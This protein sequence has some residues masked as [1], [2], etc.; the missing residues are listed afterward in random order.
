MTLAN[1]AARFLLEL[2]G[3]GAVGYWGYQAVDGMPARI[4]LAA[5]GVVA[6]VA[7]WALV[8][9][10]K[11]TNAIGQ[12]VR[13]IIGSG[14]LLLAAGAL[15]AAGHPTLA[16]VLAGAIIINTVLLFALGHELADAL[17]RSA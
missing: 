9:A 5:G 1:L 4:G 15:A 13:I 7:V 14:V 10:P 12:D 16:Q 6:L 3:I 17:P 11:A 8:S 2:V